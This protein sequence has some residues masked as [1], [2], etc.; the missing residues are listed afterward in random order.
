MVE[1][2]EPVESGTDAEPLVLV[3]GGTGTLGRAVV[4]GLSARGLAVRLLSRR[5]R[6]AG[7]RGPCRWATGDLTTGEGVD[8]AVSGAGVI[9][10]CATTLGRGDVAAT[11]RLADAA[12]RAG[13]RPHLVYISIVGVDRVP[14]PYY[15]AKLA[16]ERVVAE[17]GL[18]WTVLRATQFHD[19]IARVTDAQR[20]SP[21]ALA[22]A[23]VRFQPVDAEE[24][25]ERLA[26]LAVGEPAGRVPDMGGPQVRDHAELTRATLRARGRRRPVLPLWLPGAAF[27]GYRAGGHLAPDHAVGRITYEEY[28][29][30][31][32]R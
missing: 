3:T 16:A 8:A 28:L 11:R 5:P 19:L 1:P 30:G 10:H 27:R 32:V 26:D 21:V 7:D 25:A 13:S 20:L 4:R 14:L 31:A 2:V 23:G 29:A 9:V 17:S 12:H 15:R 18:P 22:L 6:P 24:V